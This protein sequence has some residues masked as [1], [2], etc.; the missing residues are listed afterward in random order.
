MRTL[1]ITCN[2]GWTVEALRTYERTF[3]IARHRHRVMAVRLVMEGQKGVSVARFLGLHRDR[4]S[5][6]VKNFTTGGMEGLWE[7]TPPP[8]KRPYLTEEEQQELKR[9]IVEACP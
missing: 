5:T 1:R 3:Q 9:M 6:Y 2:H 7:Q 4:V 8:G